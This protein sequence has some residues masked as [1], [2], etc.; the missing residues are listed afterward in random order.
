MSIQSHWDLNTARVH[1]CALPVPPPVTTAMRSLTLKR[2]TD[3]SAEALV[4]N[5]EAI[6]DGQI[7]NFGNLLGTTFASNPRIIELVLAHKS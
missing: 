6:E 4:G 2:K 5:V 7:H 1:L 3:S